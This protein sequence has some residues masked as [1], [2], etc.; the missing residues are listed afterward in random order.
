MNR[1]KKILMVAEAGIMIALATLLSYIKLFKMPQGGSVTAG[2]MIPL[3]F[4]AYRW[5]GVYGILV[6]A[7]YGLL[8]YFLDGY[9][10]NVW[11]LLLD[12][13]V[14][15]AC[16]GVAG[17]FKIRNVKDSLAPAHIFIGSG[18]GLGLRYVAHV[19]SGMLFFNTDFV[20]S[21][22]YNS[23]MG[24]ELAICVVLLGLL[25]SIPQTRFLLKAQ[26]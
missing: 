14:A 22:I 2:S 6:G 15:F 19:I 9:I 8:Q 1:N 16:V 12:Y 18:V 10:V 11:S 3:I 17:F 23:F 24:V 5:G 13:P 25:A 20:G 7:V 21:A 4:F 26:Y